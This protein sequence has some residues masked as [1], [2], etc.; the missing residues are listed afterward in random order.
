MYQVCIYKT[1]M[2]LSSLW[3]VFSWVGKNKMN[4]LYVR[5]LWKIGTKCLIILSCFSISLFCIHSLSSLFLILCKGN[6]NT[7]NLRVTEERPRL[8]FVS[9]TLY[10]RE[11]MNQVR[12]NGIWT[13]ESDKPY[14]VVLWCL[15]HWICVVFT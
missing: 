9:E 8:S 3:R 1:R 7:E 13:T 2:V 11:R 14:D 10:S 15:N 5:L 12:T 4:Y 6:S